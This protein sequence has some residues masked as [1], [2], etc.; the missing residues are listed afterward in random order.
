MVMASIVNRAYK[1]SQRA[2]F[3]QD[4][5]VA[6]YWTKKMT[7]VNPAGKHVEL[8][9]I[10]AS[11]A[12]WLIPFVKIPTNIIGEIGSNV[13]GLEYGL[14]K[15]G[16]VA[17]TKGLENMTEDEAASVVRNLKKGVIG[18]AALLLGYYQAENFGGF[19]QKGKKQKDDEA[20][21]MGA[22]IFGYNVP[23]WAMESPI[24]Q[25]MQLGATVRKLSDTYVKKDKATMGVWKASGHALLGLG[26]EEPLLEAPGQLFSAITNDRDRMYYLGELAKSTVDPALFN[27]IATW[28]DP[29]DKRSFGD[30]LLK[31]KNLRKPSTIMEHIETGIPG[32]RENVP[33]KTDKKHPRITHSE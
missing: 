3:M 31:S 33:L 20:G 18:T 1:D 30:E 14:A 16:H 15:I 2:I 9:N 10:R 19:Y 32:F 8:G 4:N 28:T 25:A 27:N 11:A 24:F 26:E 17:F 23:A 21:F 12:K 22:R 13:G 29:A 5:A 7:T 6:D